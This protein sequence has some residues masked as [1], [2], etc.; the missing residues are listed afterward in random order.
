MIL[1]MTICRL[2]GELRRLHK[3]TVPDAMIVASAHISNLPLV[4]RD[5]KMRSVPGVS[6]T[7]I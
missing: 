1:D 5:K 4:T 2:A 7:D 6:L 3:L